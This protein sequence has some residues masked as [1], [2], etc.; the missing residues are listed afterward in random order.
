MKMANFVNVD[1]RTPLLLP[2]DLRDW[3]P[4]DDLVHF[5]LEA[6]EQVPLSHFQV[7]ERGS[8]S[9]QFPPSMMLGLLIYCYA[10]GIFSSRKIERASYVNVA[11]RYLTADT[12]PDHDTICTFRRRNFAAITEAFVQVLQLAKELKLLKLGTISVDGTHVRASASKDQSVTAERAE[13]LEARLSEDIEALLE[14]AE[15]ADTQEEENGQKLPAEI[16]RRE[17]LREK[18]RAARAELEAR[19]QARA[20]AEQAA[21]EA[22]MQKHDENGGK[23]RA[24]KLPEPPAP[25]SREQ[26]NLTDPDSRLM[27]KNAREGYTQSYNAQAAVDADGSQ[28]IIGA[29]LSQNP[30]DATELE[31]TLAALDPRVGRPDKV[32]ADCGYANAAAF[33]RLEPDY[34]LYVSV[35]REDAHGERRYEF[36]PPRATKRPVKAIKDPRRKA[37]GEKL[38]TPEGKA[39]Y[40]KRKCTVEPVFGIIKAAMGFRQFLLRGFA[41]ASGEW[42]LVCLAY[43]C[44][45]LHRLRKEAQGPAKGPLTAFL[46][47]KSAPLKVTGALFPARWLGKLIANLRASTEL[48]PLLHWH[49]KLSP[50]SS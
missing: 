48:R 21:F 18:M 47:A 36:R 2:P 32:L 22:K 38:Q 20:A 7:N 39:L 4:E 9:K 13:Q 43:N 25:R 15:A 35:H 3:V 1:R 46:T 26:C 33:E 37:M 11:V 49:L 45:R 29:R 17:V 44:K 31:P 23:G 28:L 41:K 12:H 8:G 50:T 19:A 27:R 5:V 10:H 30:G 6:V 34:D 16:A 42:I 14:Q 40:A 24:P